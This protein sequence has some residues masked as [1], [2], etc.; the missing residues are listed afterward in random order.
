MRVLVVV[1]TV[2]LVVTTLASVVRS[3]RWWIRIWDFPRL[4]LAVLGGLVAAGYLLYL[5]P[6]SAWLNALGLI[7]VL[8]CVGWQAREI[9]RYTPLVKKQAA[10]ADS[11]KPGSTVRLL[12]TNV[13]MS[14]QHAERLLQVI[15]E[16][17]PDVILAVE[18]NRRWEEQ[19]RALERTHPYTLKE[20]RENTYGML[21]YSRFELVNPKLEH[22]VQEDIPSA[23]TGVRLPSG[24]LIE[25]HGVHP[26]PPTPTEAKDS[27]PRDVELIVV[28]KAVRASPLPGIVAGDLNDVAWSHTSRLFQ[29]I[30][31]LLDPRV[32]RGLF[33]TFHSSLPFLRFPLDHIFHCPDFRVVRMKR[34]SR[35]GSDHFPVLAELSYEPAARQAE[36]P[37]PA[38]GDHEEAAEKELG[39]RT[40]AQRLNA[41]LSELLQKH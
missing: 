36:S 1:L 6:A 34:L 17:D 8:S 38:P 23:H 28:G 41:W 18:T 12:M 5:P 14:N 40:R 29:R 37:R 24:E 26:R 20:P 9:V 25:L 27:E 35:I 4:Q 13:L 15:R 22:L 30:S 16:A 19:L 3:E 10:G 21:L 11:G 33:N 7:L 31:G 32:G 2:F 39:R